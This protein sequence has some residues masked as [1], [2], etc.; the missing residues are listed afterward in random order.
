MRHQLHS[1]GEQE[2]LQ[3]VCKGNAVTAEHVS[4][5]AHGARLDLQLGASKLGQQILQYSNAL[6][7]GAS[8]VKGPDL[9]CHRNSGSGKSEHCD[10]RG[11]NLRSGSLIKS[12]SQSV[13]GE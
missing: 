4:M 1:V 6:L 12:A 5:Y 10:Q 13:R 3:K 8:A 2:T 9:N 11:G 7:H